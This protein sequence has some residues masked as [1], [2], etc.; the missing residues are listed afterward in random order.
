MLTMI[1][2]TAGVARDRPPQSQNRHGK[3]PARADGPGAPLS[4]SFGRYGP[5][6]GTSALAKHDPPPA[7][8]AHAGKCP[9]ASRALCLVRR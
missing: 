2:S 7:Q 8:A 6:S 5:A 9:H 4:R 3:H 1:T